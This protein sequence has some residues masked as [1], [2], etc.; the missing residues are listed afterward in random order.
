VG[1]NDVSRPALPPAG[2][3]HLALTS[4]HLMANQEIRDEG[5]SSQHRRRT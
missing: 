4:L 5:S 3:T 1:V 2:S